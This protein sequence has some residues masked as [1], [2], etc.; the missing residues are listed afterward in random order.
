MPLLPFERFEIRSRLPLAEVTSRL[1]A[2]VE[3]KRWLRFGKAERPFEGRVEG[4]EFRIQR[5][6]GYRNSFL[7]RIY[8]RFTP[9]PPGCR[10]E[11]TLTLH[12]LAAAFMVVWIGAVVLIGGAFAINPPAEGRLLAHLLPVAML[13]FGWALATVPFTYEARRARRMLGELLEEVPPRS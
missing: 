5:I 8:G 2:A 11:G 12:P 7:P 6:I 3:P 10:V 9:D 13:L 4:Q 1:A